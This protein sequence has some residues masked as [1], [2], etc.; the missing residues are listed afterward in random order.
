MSLLLLLIALLLSHAARSGA[1]GVVVGELFLVSWTASPSLNLDTYRLYVTTTPGRYDRH[2]YLEVPATV[3]S[4]TGASLQLTADGQ[5]YI[6]ATAVNV[7]GIESVDSAEVAFVRDTRAPLPPID[8]PPP[9]TAPPTVAI[10]EPV[11]GGIVLRNSTQR[12]VMEA[13]DNVD[14][15]RLTVTVTE[16]SPVNWKSVCV[17]FAPPW[18]CDWKLPGAPDRRYWLNAQVID[19]SGNN[20]QHQIE[21]TSSGR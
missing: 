11:E 13:S 14:I 10:L 2:T 20:A 1:E 7:G 5:Y 3:T 6:V 8:P 12:I 9:D 4:V 18:H 21:V 17:L 16:A 15:T 19:A